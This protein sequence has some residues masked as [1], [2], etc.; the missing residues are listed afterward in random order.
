[1]S[2]KKKIAF[3][4]GGSKNWEQTNLF[5]WPYKNHKSPGA[6]M[7]HLMQKAT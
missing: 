3:W 7:S 6:H 1:M 4:K 2:M 5:V